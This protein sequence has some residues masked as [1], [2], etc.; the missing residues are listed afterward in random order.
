MEDLSS[1]PNSP[2]LKAGPAN[3]RLDICKWCDNYIKMAKMCKICK[4]I[5]PMKVRLKNAKCPIN[6][7]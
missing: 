4:C 3:A 1:I 6:K 2:I 7:W 5:M